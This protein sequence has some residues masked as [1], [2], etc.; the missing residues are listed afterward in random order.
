MRKRGRKGGGFGG[1]GSAPQPRQRGAL[2]QGML[3]AGLGGA[4]V[5]TVHRLIA[6]PP[7]P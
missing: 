3:V 2:V 7:R 4:L 1:G 6:P 5:G